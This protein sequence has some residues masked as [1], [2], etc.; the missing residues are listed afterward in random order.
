MA[1][2]Q[3]A[4]AGGD[5]TTRLSGW[6]LLAAFVVLVAFAVFVVYMIRHVSTDEVK[7]TRLGWL[8]ASVEAIAFG[9]AG[10]LFGTSIQRARAENAEA[11]ARKNADAAAKGR[12][13]ASTLVA[14]A[15]GSPG[16]AARLEALGSEQRSGE[17][18]VAARHAS[19]ARD[20]FPELRQ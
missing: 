8:F 19:V 4:G 16:G 1:A 3:Q 11:E 13:L 7:W 9:A 12:A 10:A 6:A 2:N 18:A 5:S 15:P 17:A 14:D 20:L